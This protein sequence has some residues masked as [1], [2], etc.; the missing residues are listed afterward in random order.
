[1]SGMALYHLSDMFIVTSG[2]RGLHRI[3]SG[4]F[5]YK[6]RA[7]DI[8]ALE[9]GSAID[10]AWAFASNVLPSRCTRVEAPFLKVAIDAIQTRPSPVAVKEWTAL[11]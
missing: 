9:L 10:S 11:C 5:R 4:L 2:D 3:D 1:M 7:R 8:D 6:C